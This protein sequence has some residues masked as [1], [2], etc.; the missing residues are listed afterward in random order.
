MPHHAPPLQACLARRPQA[1]PPTLSPPSA[2][3][4]LSRR[5]REAAF[6]VWGARPRG[7]APV[8]SDGAVRTIWAQRGGAAGEGAGVRPSGKL[9]HRID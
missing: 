8:D 9:A 3:Q 4:S 6:R 5:C 2:G 7:T 1:T